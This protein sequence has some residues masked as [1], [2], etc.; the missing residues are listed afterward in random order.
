MIKKILK[1][2]LHLP[3]EALLAS[4]S[5]LPSRIDA[6]SNQAILSHP[7]LAAKFYPYRP[8]STSYCVPKVSTTDQVSGSHLPIP[9]PDLWVH[10]Y[11]NADFEQYLAGGK[12]WTDNM[13]RTLE[14]S[15]VSLAPQSRILDLG[16]GDG[17]MLRQFRE[18]AQNGEAWGTD[19]NGELMIWCQ[20]HLSPPFRFVTTTSFPHLPF[21]DGYFDLVYALSVFTH[22]CDLA[23]AWLLELK[24]IVRPGGILYLTVHDRHTIDLISDQPTDL[25]LQ[26]N[27][28]EEGMR[29]RDSDFAWFTLNRAPGGGIEGD[30]GP[31][32]VFYDID[33]LAQHWGNYLE[34]VSITPEAYG[35]QTAMMLRKS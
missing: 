15:G 17:M 2:V 28:A 22:I 21:E 4:S 19:L 34:V 8:D 33:Y 27:R 16:C 25:T 14:T 23:E 7:S 32:Q 5:T 9:P 26:L 18:V 1:S 11:L 29:F 31:A 13:L 3:A 10:R 30:V 35:Y 20:Q 24:R 6:R 12:K